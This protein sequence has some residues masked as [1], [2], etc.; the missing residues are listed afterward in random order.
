MGLFPN[1]LQH[2]AVFYVEMIACKTQTAIANDKFGV[3]EQLATTSGDMSMQTLNRQ[4]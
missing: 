2:D 3:S 4:F 1:Y